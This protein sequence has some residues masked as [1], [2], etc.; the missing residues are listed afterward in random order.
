MA[1]SNSLMHLSS[2]VAN[3]SMAGPIAILRSWLSKTC[4]VRGQKLGSLFCLLF[5]FCASRMRVDAVTPKTDATE[6]KQLM[7]K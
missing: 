6:V 7:N 2:L 5:V 1:P 3:V 4:G